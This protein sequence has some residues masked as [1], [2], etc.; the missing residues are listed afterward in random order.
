MALNINELIYTWIII[1]LIDVVTI[2]KKGINAIHI[3]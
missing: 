1:S 3:I 2:N